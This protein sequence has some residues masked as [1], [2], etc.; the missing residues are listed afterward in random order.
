[1]NYVTRVKMIGLEPISVNLRDWNSW[2]VA[3]G[4]LR[5]R[6]DAE[7]KKDGCV[8]FLYCRL[9]RSS[10]ALWAARIQALCHITLFALC[11]LIVAHTPPALLRTYPIRILSHLIHI[12][13]PLFGQF[14][15]TRTCYSNTCQLLGLAI[16]TAS[17]L[18]LAQDVLCVILTGSTYAC[19]TLVKLVGLEVPTLQSPKPL[20]AHLEIE[21]ELL[22]STVIFDRG[23]GEVLVF[24]FARD[25]VR[26]IS[27]KPS[28]F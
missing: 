4:M 14:S 17:V 18:S 25:R 9:D 26:H 16:Q 3:V 15:Q 10:A 2:D 1:M 22:L 20:V 6:L 12:L 8:D 11:I 21:P 13:V 19:A 23:V 24:V 28:R 27:H 7:R 5:R